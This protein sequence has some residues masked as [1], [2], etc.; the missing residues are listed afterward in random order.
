MVV[1]QTSVKQIIDL[2]ITL[3]Y[4]EIPV[5]DKSYIFDDN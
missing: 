1:I 4:L 3:K 5:T 2:Y